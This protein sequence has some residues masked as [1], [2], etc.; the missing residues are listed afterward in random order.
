MNNPEVRV[1]YTSQIVE[2]RDKP[3]F[4]V[5]A[6]DDPSNSISSHSPSGA[7]RAVL[8][9]VLSKPGMDENRKNVSVSGT[10]R[11]GLAH[12]LVSQLIR[13]LPNAEK[14]KDI[15]GDWT[16]SPSNSPTLGRKRR[17]SDEEDAS[18]SMS[19][20]D[21]EDMTKKQKL[22]KTEQKMPK[23]SSSSLFL[24]PIF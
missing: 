17:S 8:K 23:N 6:E 3:Q 20:S 12:P 14:C 18:E 1:K 21:F 19:E 9:R 24:T 16:S 10:L 2:I 5:T 13:E 11:F 4:V 15:L 22:G 7:W